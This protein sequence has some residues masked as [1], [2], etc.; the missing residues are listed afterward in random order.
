MLTKLERNILKYSNK[1]HQANA[2][3]SSEKLLPLLKD[4]DSG[5]FLLACKQ[6]DRNGYFEYYSQTLSGRVDFFLSY[7]GLAYKE[8]ST[9]EIKS[10]LMRSVI[11]PIIV[12]LIT[13][14]ITAKVYGL[15]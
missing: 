12:A 7:K 8:H 15:L 14:L 1:L 13:T 3:I 5:N 10:F 4:V 6:L 11:T 2:C 9:L